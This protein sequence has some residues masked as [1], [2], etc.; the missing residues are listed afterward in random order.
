MG[1]IFLH[2]VVIHPPKGSHGSIDEIIPKIPS[3]RES[4]K[5]IST[6]EPLSVVSKKLD[7]VEVDADDVTSHFNHP[8]GQT[9]C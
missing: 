5:S 9:P 1:L 2:I 7:P 6:L 3:M 4:Q 8:G